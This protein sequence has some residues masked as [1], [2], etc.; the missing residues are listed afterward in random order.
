MILILDKESYKEL[1]KKFEPLLKR[2]KRTLSVYI[3]DAKVS[4]QLSSSPCA[5]IASGQALDAA[6]EKILK[7]QHAAKSN[8]LF[9]YYMR[10]KYT[11]E[12][13]PNHPIILELLNKADDN[14][15][16]LEDTI[17]VLFESTVIASGFSVRNLK[18]FSL[19]IQ[20]VIKKS[21]GIETVLDE[22]YNAGYAD[23][24]EKETTAEDLKETVG[25]TVD[26]L[27]EDHL[28]IKKDDSSDDAGNALKRDLNENKNDVPIG[29]NAHDEL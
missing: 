11:L 5:V 19:K 25:D 6:S 2:L 13:N 24:S 1:K 28:Q 4:H 8:P 27:L 7:S 17:H 10:Q 26:N 12:I 15:E 23:G 3:S 18:K 9:D 29:E 14:S 22:D 16:V 20:T 21:L